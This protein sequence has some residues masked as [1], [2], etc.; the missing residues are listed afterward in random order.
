MMDLYYA[1]LLFDA[2]RALLNLYGFILLFRALLSWFNLDPYNPV[3]QFLYRLTEPVLDPIRRILPPVGMIDFSII[4]AMFGVFAL[5][6]LL[7]ILK[8]ALLY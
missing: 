6:G 5:E 3:S 8:A 4:V 2:V 7:N 1:G